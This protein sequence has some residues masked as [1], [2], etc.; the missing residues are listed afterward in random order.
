MA[1]IHYLF[2]YLA[3][4]LFNGSV[5][6]IQNICVAS[7][8]IKDAMNLQDTQSLHVYAANNSASKQRKFELSPQ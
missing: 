5:S 3:I 7:N 6:T 8:T 1:A 2:I 4:N